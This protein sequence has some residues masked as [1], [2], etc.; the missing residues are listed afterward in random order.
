MGKWPILWV[1]SGLCQKIPMVHICLT[2][3]LSKVHRYLKDRAGL[4]SV[5]RSPA[6]DSLI[7]EASVY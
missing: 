7:K 3:N 5:L 6:P 1:N 2:R 4:M